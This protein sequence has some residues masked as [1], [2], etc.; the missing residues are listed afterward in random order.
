[1]EAIIIIFILIVIAIIS[2]I[3]WGKRSLRKD[4]LRKE[5]DNKEVK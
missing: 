1:M 5:R 3:Y 4:V 2:G